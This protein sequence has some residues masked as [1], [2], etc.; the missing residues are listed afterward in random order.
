MLFFFK[1][2]KFTYVSNTNTLRND[3][4]T[5]YD[6]FSSKTIRNEP[7]ISIPY[8][9]AFGTGKKCYDVVYRFTTSNF[10]HTQDT[11][12]LARVTDNCWTTK[13]ANWAK[14]S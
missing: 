1:A 14:T 9:D 2:G 7:I 5:Y 3:M 13:A 11:L 6:F 4:A 12:K 10:L 8:V